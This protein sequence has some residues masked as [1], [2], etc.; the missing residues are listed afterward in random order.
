MATTPD[1]PSAIPI[2]WGYGVLGPTPANWINVQQFG[3]DPT[4]NDDSTL[5]IQDALAEVPDDGGVVV[6]PPGLYKVSDSLPIKSNTKVSMYGAEIRP[7]ATEQWR[8]TYGFC[9]K[10]VNTQ[11]FDPAAVIIDENITIE[12][13][14]INYVDFLSW[15]DGS[16]HLIFMR[17]VRHVRILNMRLLNGG[18]SVALM[19]CDDTLIEGCYAEGFKNCAW[20]H[21]DG[22]SNGRVGNCYALATDYN[23]AQIMNW[24][25]DTEAPAQP[26]IVAN[27]FTC[28][29]C[30]FEST[31][32]PATPVQIEP[33]RNDGTKVR[34]VTV[35]GCVFKN[36]SLQMRGD[37]ANAIVTGNT[38]S[39]TLGGGS[40]FNCYPFVGGTPENVWFLNNQINNPTTSS[41]FGVI[42]HE[43][44]TG[45]VVGNGIYGF[46]PTDPADTTIYTTS[47]DL[48]LYGN[49]SSH[50][51]ISQTGHI[52]SGGVSIGNNDT[53][54]F[55]DTAGSRFKIK[56]LNDT[57]GAYSTDGSGNERDVWSIIGRSGFT[58][59]KIWPNTLINGYLRL[60][61][62]AGLTATGT[63]GG[64]GYQITKGYSEFTT[65][66]S[67]T[68]TRLPATASES[69]AGGRF[70]I[71]NAGAN[72]L[73]V[74]PM[75]GGQ[76]DAL[77]TNNP[78]TIAAGACKTYVAMSST[79]YRIET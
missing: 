36:C 19:G 30:I 5:A 57:F 44:T 23:E 4:G 59:F 33:L 7:V 69:V 27:G 55:W 51:V 75:D 3:A 54:G 6:I 24:N 52:G 71:W 41:G 49:Q 1:T 14:T 31:D 42:R 29:N 68:G 73:N 26:N 16:R 77:G 78:D 48:V 60:T 10:N 74:Y 12:G 17:R 37:I 28:T 38:F 79:L 11:G 25:P 20:D 76:I 43:G 63:T 67:G 65:V 53:L 21:W 56:T 72:T 13:G 45:G 8:G 34:N 18:D 46:S 22:P 58:D 66:A 35:T 70:V 15:P 50:S 64:T 2:D 39:D 47:V 9:F 61:V 62:A 32:T 40:V